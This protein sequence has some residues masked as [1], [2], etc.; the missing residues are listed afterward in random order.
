MKVIM[1]KKQLLEALE[2]LG[3]N[4]SV[5]IDTQVEFEIGED[6]YSF[7][8]DVIGGIE[9]EDGSYINEIRLIPIKGE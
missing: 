1:N 5:V 7:S 9:L 3:D 8:V 4:D 6:L 2:G